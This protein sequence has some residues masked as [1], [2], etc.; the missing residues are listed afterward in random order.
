MALE[1]AFRICHR[2][3]KFVRKKDTCLAYAFFL[4]TGSSIE[5]TELVTVLGMAEMTLHV[6]EAICPG[7]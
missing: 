2:V 3:L 5:H 7:A 6:G 1:G 4:E